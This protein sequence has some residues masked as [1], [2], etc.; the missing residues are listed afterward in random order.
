[1]ISGNDGVWPLVERELLL[2]SLRHSRTRDLVE[3]GRLHRPSWFVHQ[4][5]LLLLHVGHLLMMVGHRLEGYASAPLA[6]ERR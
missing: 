2:E 5:R 4:V 3:E 6:A 1:M